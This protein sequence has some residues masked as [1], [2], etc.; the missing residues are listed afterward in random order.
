MQN[1]GTNAAGSLSVAASDQVLVKSEFRDYSDGMMF[2]QVNWDGQYVA[3][4]YFSSTYNGALF[5][6][7][8]LGETRCGFIQP[9]SIDL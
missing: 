5:S 6:M 3:G 4:L 7:T 1:Y 9:N 8:R 2:A